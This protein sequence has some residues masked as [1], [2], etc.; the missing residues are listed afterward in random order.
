MFHWRGWAVSL[1]R[2]H[3]VR[4]GGGVQSVSLPCMPSVFSGSFSL[5]RGS[6]IF[7]VLFHGCLH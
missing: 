2:G 3:F 4:V 7:S 6:H 1:E 5:L